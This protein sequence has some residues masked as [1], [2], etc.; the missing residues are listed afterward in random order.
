MLMLLYICLCLCYVSTFVSISKFMSLSVFV[1]LCSK[2]CLCFS[3]EY[4]SMSMLVVCLYVSFVYNINKIF[5]I[6][7]DNSHGTHFHMY[8]ALLVITL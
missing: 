5:N 3:S 8:T 4:V 7:A 6:P 2:L 1:C